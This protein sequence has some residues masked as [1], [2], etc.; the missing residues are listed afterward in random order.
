MF[1]INE[2]NFEKIDVGGVNK[3]F[4]E[5]FRRVFLTRLIP[6]KLYEKLGLYEE[7]IALINEIDEKYYKSE[8]GHQKAAAIRER[9]IAAK[10]IN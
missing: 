4:Q 3:Q 2:L 1:K 10:K 9:L 6:K 7:G 5:I 8:Y